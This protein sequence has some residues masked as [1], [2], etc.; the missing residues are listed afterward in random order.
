M[1]SIVLDLGKITNDVTVAVPA[2]AMPINRETAQSEILNCATRIT[3]ILPPPSRR[4]SFLVFR[5]A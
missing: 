1:P 5:V 4:F 2:I 3:L